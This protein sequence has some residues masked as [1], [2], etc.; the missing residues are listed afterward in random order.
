MIIKGKTVLLSAPLYRRVY[1]QERTYLDLLK[2]VFQ[3]EPEG[4]IPL[5]RVQQV[6]R[7]LGAKTKKAVFM[8]YGL[9]KKNLS[10]EEVAA[11]LDVRKEE[12]EKILLDA[13]DKLRAAEFLKQLLGLEPIRLPP[14]SDSEDEGETEEELEDEFEEYLKRKK[15]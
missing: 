15:G 12:I 13:I 2:L 11:A 10:L 5:K 8:F 7:K 14:Y 4:S 3:K 6:V 9:E 1:M